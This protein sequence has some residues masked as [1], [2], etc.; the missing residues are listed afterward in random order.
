MIINR[1]KNK[2][3]PSPEAAPASYLPVISMFMPFEPKMFREADLASKLVRLYQQAERL[4][5][6]DFF[7]AGKKE[8]LNRLSTVISN[9]NFSTHKRSLA[10]YVTTEADKVFYLDMPLTE[11]VRVGL[12]YSIRSLVDCKID[13]KSFLVL[14]M[15]EYSSRICLCENGIFSTVT[16]THTH[17][18]EQSD[19]SSFS[20]EVFLKQVDRGLSVILSSFSCPL[21][22]IG[23]AEILNQYKAITKNKSRICEMIQCGSGCQSEEQIKEV[24]QP[25]I[26]DWNKVKNRFLIQ[27][28]YEASSNKKLAVG[29]TNVLRVAKQK[30]GELLI[31]ERSY[32]YPVIIAYNDKI[33]PIKKNPRG[34]KFTDLLDEAIEAVLENGGDVEFVHREFLD[35]FMHVALLHR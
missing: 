24:M 6:N 29:A 10:I 28:L 8:V 4:V 13:V 19:A 20:T 22:V 33:D 31:V 11:M 1:S 18:N 16:N 34:A 21:F 30:K 27:T 9:I 5:N 2:Q 3:V 25:H 35:K 17:S 7:V 12:S 14:A 32:T 23:T 15:D 26:A